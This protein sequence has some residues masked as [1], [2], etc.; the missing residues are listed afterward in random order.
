M[1]TLLA[2][3]F[4][5]QRLRLMKL[6]P[7]VRIFTW[8]LGVYVVIVEIFSPST[9]AL[10]AFAA[11]AGVAIGFASQD[12]LKNI[13]G[14]IVII[15]DRPFQVGDKIQVGGY[16][17]EVVSIGLRT[18]RIVTPDDSLVSIPNSELVNQSVSNS[19]AGALDCQVVVEFV[20]PSDVDLVLAKKILFE[21][22]A[23]SRYIYLK[24]PIAVVV[25]DDFEEW[26]LT[27]VKVKAYVLDNRYENAF[28]SEITETAKGAFIEAGIYPA[29]D[30]LP[31]GQMR[32][33]LA[34][35]RAGP[36]QVEGP[37]QIQTQG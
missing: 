20:L 19:N 2:E 27:K 15:L 1:L 29:D 12:I 24:K 32:A 16:Y 8:V 21:A 22:A 6:V 18:V 11:S 26:F 33:L 5:T 9:N 7:I 35:R 14:G 13:F 37:G 25:Q 28:A 4:G 36:G 23:T 30:H 31:V 3:R 34:G 17:G 10:L